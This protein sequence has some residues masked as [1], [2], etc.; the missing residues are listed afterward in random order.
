MIRLAAYRNAFAQRD[1]RRLWLGF[2]ISV[3][4]D[5]FTLVAFVWFVLERTRSPEALGL[6]MAAF[7]GPRGPARVSSLDRETAGEPRDPAS[8][9]GHR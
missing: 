1:F 5:S 6:L 7:T 2:T 3:F 4:G 9:A 8:G